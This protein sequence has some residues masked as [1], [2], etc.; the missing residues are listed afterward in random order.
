M[1]MNITRFVA[2]SSILAVILSTGSGREKEESFQN[3]QQSVQE[4]S[5]KTIRWE[6]DQAAH[7]QALQ[8]VRLLLRGSLAVDTAV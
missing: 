5:G 6:E 2:C 3:V 1:L 7:E 4:R 8:D